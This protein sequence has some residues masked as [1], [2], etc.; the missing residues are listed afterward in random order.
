MS[1]ILQVHG[2]NVSVKRKRNQVHILKDLSFTLERGKWLGVIG[3]SGAGK[4]TLAYAISN[5]ILDKSFCISGHISFTSDINV[6]N[7]SFKEKRRLTLDNVGIIFQNAMSALDPYE[8]IEKQMLELIHFKKSL[9]KEEGKRLMNESLKMVGLDKEVDCIHK[10]PS[11]L[12]GGMRQR[13]LLAMSVIQSPPLLIADEPT[14]SLDGLHK[15]SF[16]KL[17]KNVSNRLGMSVVYISHDLSLV[18][19]FCDDLL[20]LDKGELVTKGSSETLLNKPDNVLLKEMI[21]N[22]RR[23]I[24]DKNVCD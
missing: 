11:Q 5:M 22:T 10:Y 18:A 9:S 13:V 15:L 2:L 4:S 21:D 14:S 23:I 7:L 3:P 17:L 12:S 16:L 1:K 19:Q 8:R 6:L 24:G 20:V